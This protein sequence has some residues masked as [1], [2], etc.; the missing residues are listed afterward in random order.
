MKK[1]VTG[2]LVLGAVMGSL[3]VVQMP[4]HAQQQRI[5]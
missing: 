3:A 1:V 5:K 4:Q 2:S